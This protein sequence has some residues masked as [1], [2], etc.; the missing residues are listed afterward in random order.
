M[1]IYYS[2]WSYFTTVQ[3]RKIENVTSFAVGFQ[4]NIHK[5]FLGQ[6]NMYK[7]ILEKKSCE[8]ENS[9][10]LSKICGRKSRKPMVFDIRKKVEFPTI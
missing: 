10:M 2:K 7:S 5:I 8:N 4:K 1:A 9:M 3:N 6:K